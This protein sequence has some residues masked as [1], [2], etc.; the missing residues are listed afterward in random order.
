VCFQGKY[1]ML[2][3][4]TSQFYRAIVPSVP[5]LYYFYDNREGGVMWF[6]VILM[7]L[8]VVCKVRFNN[9]FI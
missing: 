9:H 4:V 1:Y 2:I 7:V 5:W 8:Y 3:E 6:S